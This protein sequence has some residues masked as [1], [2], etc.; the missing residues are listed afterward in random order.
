ML[1]DDLEKDKF[2]LSRGWREEENQRTWNT[3]IIVMHALWRSRGVLG[4][5]ILLYLLGELEDDKYQSQER[6]SESER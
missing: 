6:H 5:G 3:A 4:C 2:W 1:Y